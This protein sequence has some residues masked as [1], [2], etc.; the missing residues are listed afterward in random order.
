MRICHAIVL[1]VFWLFCSRPHGYGAGAISTTSSTTR[2]TVFGL[3]AMQFAHGSSVLD[4]PFSGAF[5]R[6]A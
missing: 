6:A 2:M 3:V 1:S 4:V 5:G